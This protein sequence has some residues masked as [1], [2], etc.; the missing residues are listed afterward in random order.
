M[1]VD[2]DDSD[3]IDSLHPLII[4]YS[5]Q[6]AL[7]HLIIIT[8]NCHQ[9]YLFLNLKFINSEKSLQNFHK[10]NIAAF[11]LNLL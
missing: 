3:M 7:E 10:N 6:N 11:I 9:Y 8:H 5:Y 4:E 2:G 1:L